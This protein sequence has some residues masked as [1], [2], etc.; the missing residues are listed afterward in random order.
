M[1]LKE[2]I[3]SRNNC[4]FCGDDLHLMISSYS[5][6]R[7]PTLSLKDN[8]LTIHSM[9]FAI[10]I[11]LSSETIIKGK[12]KSHWEF[13]LSLFCPTHTD[14]E[15]ESYKYDLVFDIYNGNIGNSYVK[16]TLTTEKFRLFYLSLLNDNT[17]EYT[18][19]RTRTK[20]IFPYF[21]YSNMSL[22]KLKSKI[23]TY[24]IMQ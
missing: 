23:K 9:F 13:I 21:D 1:R 22:P 3:D 20:I 11:D 14:L 19:R 16:E 5:L 18:D 8:V 12:D 6:S 4:P 7:S 2:F 15:Y 17:I 24:L 10:E